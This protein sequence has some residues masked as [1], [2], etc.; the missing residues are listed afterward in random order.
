MKEIKAW[1]LYFIFF[2]FFILGVSYIFPKLDSNFKDYFETFY[3]AIVTA[4]TVGYGDITPHT[5][6]TKTI[7]IIL[8]ILS[9]V[10]VSLFTAIVTNRLIQKT[11]FKIREWESVDEL[12]NHLIICGY[13]TQF[14][15][16]L[17]EFIKSN[18]RFNVDGIVIINEEL[19][20]AIELILEEI[21]HIKFVK[22]DFSEEEIL[23]KAKAENATKAI[24]IGEQNENSD[25]K[26]L[27][28]S[29]LL[30]SLNK[31]I[32]LIAEINNPKFE[33]YLEKIEC[34]EII[35]N[36]EYNKYLLSKAIT[37]PGISKVI[38]NLIKDKNFKIIHTPKI[39]VTY[40]EIFDEMLQNNSL[41]IGVI[42]NYGNL[43]QLKQ[44]YIKEAEESPNIDKLYDKI[45]EL[46][47]IQLNKVI[48]APA[49]DYIIQ[50]NTALIILEK[51]NNV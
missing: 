33:R 19:T 15:T 46:K 18:K 49:N 50:K 37:D 47:N 22:G 38:G 13:K 9:T 29:I 35:L 51:D 11:I 42:E 24:I 5:T 27:A 41:L 45:H 3:W 14:K 25:S 30:K 16:L 10:A 43:K 48:L 26:V 21:K 28:T 20:P 2:I 31:N 32:Y 1:I 7:T 23:V 6:L 4:S 8:I 36:E 39:S 34:D 12:N 44:E 40:K 17:N